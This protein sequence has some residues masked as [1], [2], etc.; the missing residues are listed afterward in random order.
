[1]YDHRSALDPPCWTQSKSKADAQC[2]EAIG[3]IQRGNR[4]AAAV[5]IQAALTHCPGHCEASRL[6]RLQTTSLPST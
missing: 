2:D 5:A 6:Y 1:M 3:H 4:G